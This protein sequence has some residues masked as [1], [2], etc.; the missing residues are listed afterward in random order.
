MDTAPEAEPLLTV[1]EAAARLRVSRSTMYRLIRA[2]VIPTVTVRR[3]KRV[4]PQA[5]SDFVAVGGA[6]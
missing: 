6:A 1:D 5:V 4:A 2:G 3:A